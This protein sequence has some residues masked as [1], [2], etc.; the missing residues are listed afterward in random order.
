MENLTDIYKFNGEI[1]SPDLFEKYFDNILN[2]LNKSE[3]NI[4][5]KLV[6]KLLIYTDE[7]N[8]T[9]IYKLLSNNG[10]ELIDYINHVLFDFTFKID[11]DRIKFWII[12][13]YPNNKEIIF[14]LWLLQYKFKKN[15]LYIN[16]N[17]INFE[18]IPIIN[19]TQD[20]KLSLYYQSKYLFTNKNQGI[21]LL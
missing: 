6:Y 20:F 13:L 1:N 2:I 18:D 15:L 7:I 14:I 10:L 12:Y 4:N 16:D 21:S 8:F 9:E 17:K 3:L 11:D 19:F 5:Q